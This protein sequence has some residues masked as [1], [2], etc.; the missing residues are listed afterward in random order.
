M[1]GKE[2]SGRERNGME[3]RRKSSRGLGGMSREVWDGKAGTR[4]MDK[5]R[6]DVE[7][8]RKTQRRG[9]KGG[10]RWREQVERTRGAAVKNKS[11][12]WK[13]QELRMERTRAA[14]RKNKRCGWKGQ[15]ARVERTKSTKKI[16]AH[17]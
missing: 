6:L 7:S 10:D 8:R 13:E 1:N 14:D 5:E 15:G 4:R 16:T 12:G 17:S 3:R 9:C 2:R 11:C